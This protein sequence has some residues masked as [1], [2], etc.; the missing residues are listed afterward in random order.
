MKFYHYSDYNIIH[1]LNMA[2]KTDQEMDLVMAQK[3]DQEIDLALV[4]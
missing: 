4:I 2:Q 1:V 3:K